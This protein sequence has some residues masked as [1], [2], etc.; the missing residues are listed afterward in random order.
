MAESTEHQCISEEQ[1]REFAIQ[2]IIT[3]GKGR[4]TRFLAICEPCR[5]LIKKAI[6][7]VSPDELGE[8]MEDK[9]SEENMDWENVLDLATTFLDYE[10]EEYLGGKRIV[11]EEGLDLNDIEE[12]ERRWKVSDM[13]RR[14]KIEQIKK[15]GG[16]KFQEFLGIYF[17]GKYGFREAREKERKV[18]NYL[19]ALVYRDEIKTVLGDEAHLAEHA[20]LAEKISDEDI[21]LH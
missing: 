17:E 9:E 19:F 18:S 10:A 8:K 3:V 11:Q 20:H 16:K 12:V 15:K 7:S 21:T 2:Q 4:G 6:H 13:I 14:A 5:N 1:A